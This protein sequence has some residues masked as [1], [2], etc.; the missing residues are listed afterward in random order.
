MVVCFAVIVQFDSNICMEIIT[1]NNWFLLKGHGIS[2][3][4]FREI[5]RVVPINGHIE[6]TTLELD[7][8]QAHQIVR[9]PNGPHPLLQ[10]VDVFNVRN[11][12]SYN[13][14]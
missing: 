3:R 5:N 6:A 4:I 13:L 2:I 7:F 11:F 8:N 14:I 1:L 12:T 10:K 9:Q